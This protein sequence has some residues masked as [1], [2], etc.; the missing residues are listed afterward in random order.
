MCFRNGLCLGRPAAVPITG[1]IAALALLLQTAPA[2]AQTCLQDEYGKVQR[3]KL[4]CTA[5][6]VRIAQVTNIRDPT[7]GQKITTCF[8]GSTF[9]FLADFEVLTTS[10]QAREN[11]GLYIATNSTTQALTGACVDNI[12]TRTNSDNYH[13]TDP[14]PDNCGDTASSDLSPT[15]GAGAEKITLR[16]DNFSCTAPAGSSTLVLPN[17]TSWQ[18]PGGTIQCVSNDGTYPLNGPGGTPTAIPGSPSKCNC[19]VISL[20]IT[21]VTATAIVQKAC[22]TTNT[23]G[24]AA[25]TQTPNVTQSPTQCDAGQEGSSVS[26]TVSITNTSTSGGLVI[27]QVCDN[28]YGTI[29][30]SN[31]APAALAACAA[32][33]S[34]ITATNGVCNPTT[35]TAAGQAG[36]TGQCTFNAVV[37]ENVSGLTDNVT[38]YGHSPLNPNS[39]FSQAS[40]S[41]TVTSTDAPSTAT[42]TKGV[43]GTT[44]ACATVRYSVDVKN[45]SKADENLTLTALSDTPYGD[46]TH[47]QGSV[48][49]TTCGVATG[50]AGLGT[51]SASTG[52]GA[53]PASL[54]VGGSDYTCQFDAQFCSALDANSCIS[55]TDK[56]GGSF[57]ADEPAD[58]VT[59]TAN[60]ITVKECL[61]TTVT[62][63]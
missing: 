27:D 18:I 38:A 19:S 26:Y 11:I 37:G 49:G 61:T 47:V 51:L 40:N 34:G 10:S 36:A 22:T 28:Q 8:Q 2:S 56:V 50:T 60:T 25:F 55:H 39:T 4:N 13:E 24:P 15:F 45:T 5:N 12:I 59:A 48:L 7:T 14:T 58:Q 23:P 31:T 35:L 57:T 32:G 62:S 6:D 41:V 29:F 53:L 43:V 52:A 20:P 3:Q 63:Q 42:I 17:C 16:V 9:S 46:V 30:R 33:T 21:P 44:A 54:L 1:A